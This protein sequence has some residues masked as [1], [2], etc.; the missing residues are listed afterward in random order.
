MTNLFKKRNHYA[1]YKDYCKTK[2][3]IMIGKHHFGQ[4]VHDSLLKMKQSLTQQLGTFV[5]K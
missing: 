5:V 2:K 3:A 1:E 4:E